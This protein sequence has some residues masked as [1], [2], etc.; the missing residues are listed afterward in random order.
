MSGFC[1]ENPVLQAVCGFKQPLTQQSSNEYY[2]TCFD[3]TPRLT[4]ISRECCNTGCQAFAVMTHVF[5]CVWMHAGALVG[6][7]LAALSL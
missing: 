3:N 5:T 4:G 6:L 2:V 7:H 1:L